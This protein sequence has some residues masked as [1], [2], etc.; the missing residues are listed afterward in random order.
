MST[1]SS[2]A[3]RKKR[4]ELKIWDRETGRN[5]VDQKNV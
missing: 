2:P 3:D 5:I 4:I 1:R